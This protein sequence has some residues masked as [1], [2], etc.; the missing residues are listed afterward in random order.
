MENPR[1]LFVHPL[2]MNSFARK[3]SL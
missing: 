1:A 3:F 2:V